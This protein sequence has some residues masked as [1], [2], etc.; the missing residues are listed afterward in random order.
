MSDSIVLQLQSLASD[1]NSNIEELLNKS[2]LVARKLKIKEFRKWCE[3][4]LEGYEKNT[5]PE[6]RKFRGQLK[7]FNPYHG[8]QTF[9][10]PDDLDEVVTSISINLSVGEINNLLKQDGDSFENVIS[11]QA[12]RQLMSLQGGYDLE[13][14]VIFKRSQLLGI[15]SKLRNIILNWSLQLEE[16]GI[17]GKGLKF[18]D[19]E[20]EAAMSVNHFNIQNLQGVAGTISGG[21]INQNNQINIKEMDFDSLAKYLAANNI[22]FSDIQTLKE[23]IQHDSIPTESNKLGENVSGWIATMMGKAANGSWDIGIATAGTLLAQ[24]IASFY[25]LG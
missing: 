14:R 2:L 8:F 10:I 9:I 5:L 7:V 17:L 16:D 20:K 23:A 4:E 22:A 19:K 6:Y 24:S 3:L 21:T 11:N 18:S 13:P 15:T 1:P 12:K 25:G